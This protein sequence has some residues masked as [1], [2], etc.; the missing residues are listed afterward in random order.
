LIVKYRLEKYSFTQSPQQCKITI[1][2]A[3]KADSWPDQTYLKESRMNKGIKFIIL[4]GI[5]SALILQPSFGLGPGYYHLT[6][7]EKNAVIKDIQKN[8]LND[9]V[10]AGKRSYTLRVGQTMY[11]DFYQSRPEYWDSGDSAIE[12]LTRI[13]QNLEITGV[14]SK[15]QSDAFFVPDMQSI[16]NELDRRDR[17]VWCKANVP[18]MGMSSEFRNKCMDVN[19]NPASCMDRVDLP[20]LREAGMLTPELYEKVL[21]YRRTEYIQSMKSMVSEMIQVSPEGGAQELCSYRKCQD[22]FQCSHDPTANQEAVTCSSHSECDS[23]VCRIPVDSEDGVGVCES[24]SRCFPALGRN[25][26]CSENPVCGEELSCRSQSLD[27]S[28]P[29]VDL[30]EDGL[31]EVNICMK[32]AEIGQSPGNGNPCCPGSVSNPDEGSNVCV[33]AIPDDISYDVLIGKGDFFLPL[34]EPAMNMDQ[35]KFDWYQVYLQ[36][37]R[38]YPAY[39]EREMGLLA[40]EFMAGGDDIVEDY[41]SANSRMKNVSVTRRIMRNWLFRVLRADE[42]NKDQVMTE[43]ENEMKTTTEIDWPRKLSLRDQFLELFEIKYQYKTV[44]NEMN[45]GLSN[46]DNLGIP[47]GLSAE[48]VE[49]CGATHEPVCGQPQM[50]KCEGEVCSQEMP[51]PRKYKNTCIREAAGAEDVGEELC[52]EG[53]GV[54]ERIQASGERANELAA[55]VT[56]M[57][58]RLG[59]AEYNINISPSFQEID[60][61]KQEMRTKKWKEATYKRYTKSWNE[62]KSWFKIV[63]DFMTNTFKAFV[64]LD[65]DAAMDVVNDM[66]GIVTN[67]VSLNSNTLGPQLAKG[68]YS[69]MWGDYPPKVKRTEVKCRVKWSGIKCEYRLDINWPES[70]CDEGTKVM[71]TSGACLKRFSY[72]GFRGAPDV[73]VDPFIPA[74]MTQNLFFRK[75]GK[76]QEN[77]KELVDVAALNSINYLKA[78]KKPGMNSTAIKRAFPDIKKGRHS[79]TPEMKEQIKTAAIKYLNEQY[80]KSYLRDEFKKTWADYA[81]KLHFTYPK[82]SKGSEDIGYPQRGFPIYLTSLNSMLNKSSD[83][84][85]D[86]SEA[87]DQRIATY[88]T[89]LDA[90][91]QSYN[92]GVNQGGRQGSEQSVSAEDATSQ[93]DIR[94]RVGSG[95]GFETGAGFSFNGAKGTTGGDKSQN[96]GQVGGEFGKGTSSGNSAIAE[97]FRNNRRQNAKIKQEMKER[98]AKIK[99][100]LEK[101]G[102]NFEKISN[103]FGKV[104]SSFSNPS[105]GSSSSGLDAIGKNS[106]GFGS[107]KRVDEEKDSATSGQSIADYEKYQ[108]AG[109]YSGNGISKN[110]AF[111]GSSNGSRNRTSK[112]RGGA[113]ASSAQRKLADTIKA[114]DDARQAPAVNASD[115][116][117]EMVTKAYI[118]SYHKLLDKRESLE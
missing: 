4:S 80:P 24:V 73:L 70:T 94:T 66:K 58:Q 29:G 91:A 57:E 59:Q 38:E 11:Q 108:R 118:R 17:C 93:L 26:D 52:A 53:E 47:D 107:Q 81:L 112:N 86:N 92:Q 18:V 8:F 72:I 90:F 12:G 16:Q 111:Y 7:S 49:E 84:I 2:D 87:L 54:G 69:T 13:V 32:C 40:F 28:F 101:K 117:F 23:R 67:D 60:D 104:F 1:S 51:R 99:S 116:L 97:A 106:L 82:L 10:M 79:I 64:A 85:E 61:L 33:Q 34:D 71:G 9:Q 35:C 44:C 21:P 43:I 30:N 110:S 76:E 113:E 14:F 109:S 31:S 25:E 3:L 39:F 95:T 74:G 50:P 98:T 36:R 62:R 46:V 105:A 55:F 5:L 88:Q 77:F 41:W 20:K 78:R 27:I 96:N 6:D 19:I 22:S 42:E 115:S 45:A 102:E 65:L 37:L 75:D 68:V 15:E 56:L 89:Y 114:M 48:A 103:Q 100:S 63:G 83:E